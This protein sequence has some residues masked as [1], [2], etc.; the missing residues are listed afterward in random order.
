MT[1]LL[2]FPGVPAIFFCHG[3][4]PWEETPP[5]FPRILRY[6]AVD[7]TCLDRLLLE[8]AI[9]EEKT[10]VLLNFVDLD[11]FKP[12][13]ALPQTPSRALFFS[14]SINEGDGLSAVRQACQRFGV[15][16]DVA[17]LRNGNPL[18]SPELLLGDYDLVFAK[19]R[20]ALEA[21]AVGSA[22]ILC[23]AAG[24]GPMVIRAGAGRE[25]TIDEIVGLYH[26]VIA[27]YRAAGSKNLIGEEH[28]AAEYLRWLA[29]RLKETDQLQ[30]QVAALNEQ[31]SNLSLQVAA[32]TA[33]LVPLTGSDTA[34]PP[35]AN[36]T[37]PGAPTSE[38]ELTSS[39]PGR[40]GTDNSIRARLLRPVLSRIKKVLAG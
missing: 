39:H 27:E 29:Q 25:Q 4:M 6:V 22:V 9:P 40:K 16:L 12:R 8:H 1:A 13:V 18:A 26:E 31:V 34:S 30:H 21:L 35:L 24:A 10:R 32:A 11:R 3:W 15:S 14:N 23:D 37:S 19:A 20:A 2:R 5:R 17:G 36:T 28:A 38:V 7:Y 33:A